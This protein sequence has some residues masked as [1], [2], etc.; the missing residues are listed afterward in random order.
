MLQLWLLANT[1]HAKRLCKACNGTK[2][3]DQRQ[4]LDSTRHLQNTPRR[5]AL[6]IRGGWPTPRAPNRTMQSPDAEQTIEKAMLLIGIDH[7][8]EHSNSQPAI[9]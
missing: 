1:P 6:R 9:G 5:Q 3:Q 7:A 8:P 4:K 2:Y